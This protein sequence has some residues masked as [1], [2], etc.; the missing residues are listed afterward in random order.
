M[1]REGTR[2]PIVAFEYLSA[3]MNSDEVYLVGVE[4]ESRTKHTSGQWNK[5]NF[6]PHT[7][8]NFIASRAVKETNQ[9]TFHV[10]KS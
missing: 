9:F 6:A 1:L 8:K 5:A 10:A 7:R 4:L 3:T 2:E